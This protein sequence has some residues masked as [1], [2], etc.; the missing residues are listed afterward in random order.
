MFE[1]PAILHR[2]LSCSRHIRV[3]WIES[4]TA[5]SRMSRP[6][7]S[8]P[9]RGSAEITVWCWSSKAIGLLLRPRTEARDKQHWR[10]GNGR[11]RNGR[12]AHRDYRRS[13]CPGFDPF[14]AAC[15]G[16][17]VHGRHMR[18]DIRLGL[19]QGLLATDMLDQ[20]PGVLGFLEGGRQ[21]GGDGLPENL[22]RL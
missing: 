4:V 6:T 16:V 2:F 8:N 12:H 1:D 21:V 15:L 7:G 14:R 3:R 13:A 20:V 5:P 10:S 17:S 22:A 18:T 9:H 19:D 11:R